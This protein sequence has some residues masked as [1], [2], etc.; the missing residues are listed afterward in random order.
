MFVS[1][2]HAVEGDI[3]TYE[4]LSSFFLVGTASR[5]CQS[6]GTW[7]G[8][9]PVCEEIISTWIS[10]C[11]IESLPLINPHAVIVECPELLNPT[12]G[13]VLVNNNP[14]E[15]DIALYD[16]SS[17]FI[18]VGNDTRVCQSDGTWSG[19]EPVCEA[20]ILGECI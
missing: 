14:V 9:A 18:L 6:D 7:S 4:C 13:F 11:V 10:S 8:S 16:C 19:S 17:S 3:A 15:G 5:I 2:D 12:N 1:D 20:V